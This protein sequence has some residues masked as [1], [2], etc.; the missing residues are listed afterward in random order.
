MKERADPCMGHRCGY[1]KNVRDLSHP[2]INHRPA[3][4]LIA[5]CLKPE[6]EAEL[7]TENAD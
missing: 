2:T 4:D 6:G 5:D 1:L 3:I 7:Q